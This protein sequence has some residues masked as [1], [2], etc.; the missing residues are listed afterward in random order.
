MNDIV[1][2]DRLRNSTL[3]RTVRAVEKSMG[4]YGV[5]RPLTIEYKTYLNNL[6]RTPERRKDEILR[7]NCSKFPKSV[8]EIPHKLNDLY[9]F[10]HMGRSLESVPIALAV[11]KSLKALENEFPPPGIRK[12][13]ITTTT[14]DSSRRKPSKTLEIDE[15]IR[16]DLQ[17]YSQIGEI[18]KKLFSMPDYVQNRDRS[19]VKLPESKLKSPPHHFNLNIS[20]VKALK[21]KVGKGVVKQEVKRKKI[22]DLKRMLNPSG[23]KLKKI[24]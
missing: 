16:K 10:S 1:D 17:K 22:D 14:N 24:L 15:R 8:H 4:Q 21:T 6:P 3:N 11:T 7:I 23:K 5:T 18:R 20:K 2:D 9:V 13:T 12:A 19:G